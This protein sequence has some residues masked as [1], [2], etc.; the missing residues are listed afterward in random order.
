M[1]KIKDIYDG[2]TWIKFS[3]WKTDTHSAN[4]IDANSYDET[5]AT[6]N[7]LHREEFDK[8]GPHKTLISQQSM[9]ET[10]NYY[11]KNCTNYKLILILFFK[12]C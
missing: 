5:A 12:L 11:Y 7:E 6:P 1:N 9:L 10:Y 4:N 3:V 2:E 8:N